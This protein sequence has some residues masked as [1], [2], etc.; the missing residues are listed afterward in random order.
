MYK[1]LRN[2]NMKLYS[3]FGTWLMMAFLLLIVA[4]VGVVNQYEAPPPDVSQWRTHVERDIEEMKAG[5][6]NEANPQIVKQLENHIK[7]KK[8]ALSHGIVP[9]EYTPWS[10]TMEGSSMIPLVSLFVIFVAG[11][12]VANEFA[13]GT[14][15]SLLVKPHSRAKILLAK[16]LSV[17]QFALLLFVMLFAAT[18]AC[19]GLLYDFSYWDTPYLF[20]NAQGNVQEGMM[21]VHLFSVYLLNSVELLFVATI[22][23]MISS[24]FRSPSLAIGISMLLLLLG[25]LTTSLLAVKYDWIKY[26]LFANTSLSM[27]LEGSPLIEGM[28]LPFSLIVLGIYFIAFILTTWTVFTKRDVVS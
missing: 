27:Y 4:L 1:L 14:I 7:V 10:Y 6:L 18:F 17:L 20:V 21:I 22:S 2:E 15:K 9:L 24:V 16:Y 23:F 28:T 3:K 13:S 5:I 12:I 19:N 11:G 25:G 8:Y 26:T